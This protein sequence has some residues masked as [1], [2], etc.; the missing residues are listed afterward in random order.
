MK[1]SEAWLLYHRDKTM[2]RYSPHTLEAYKYQARL[3]ARALG[4]CEISEITRDMLKDYLFGLTHLKP[5]SIAHRHRFLQSLFRWAIDEGRVRK[6]PM[7]G[8]KEP[9]IDARVPKFMTEEEVV[10][11]KASCKLDMERAMIEFFYATGGR[12]GEIYQ[13]NKADIDWEKNAL[14]VHGKGSRDREVFFSIECKIWLKRYLQSRSDDVSALFI[15]ERR[16]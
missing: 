1:I 7:S 12:V 8:I 10:T 13:I 14:I 15:T 5:S 16:P 11:L 4:D 2:I 3:L 6:N 9:K